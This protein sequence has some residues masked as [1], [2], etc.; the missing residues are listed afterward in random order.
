MECC[1]AP[2]EP[3]SLERESRERLH[4]L[5]GG[6]ADPSDVASSYS[7]S[8]EPSPHVAVVILHFNG[9]QDT[10]DCLQ[11]LER[12]THR[13]FDV[14]VVDNSGTYHE[15]SLLKQRFGDWLHLIRNPTNCGVPE[16]WNTGIRYALE[17]LNPA[18]ILLLNNDAIAAP[19]L[20]SELVRIA[21]E[22]GAAACGAKVLCHDNPNKLQF[23]GGRLYLSLGR[24][25]L[26]GQ[27][28]IDLGQYDEV[29][30]VDW[31]SGCCFLIRR[32]ALGSVGLFDAQYFSYF[33]DADWCQRARRKGLQLLYVP[34]AVV[35]HK[36]TSRR[37]SSR[38][39]YFMVRNH[40]L[41]VRKHASRLQMVTALCYLIF[42][43]IPMWSYSLF[44]RQPI[45]T[46]KAVGRALVWHLR[47]IG[48][49]RQ[50]CIQDAK[51]TIAEDSVDATQHERSESF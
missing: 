47:D 40:L 23:V 12:V 37:I 5:T 36:H 21:E 7:A 18:Y 13:Q 24:T 50:L 30:E 31:L 44:S 26:V 20:L 25:A 38:K 41:F 22:S 15:G 3:T 19:G 27:G 2:L 8:R 29:R 39:L 17:E 45:V 42:Y 43:A 32:E 14:I 11:S 6:P 4:R 35:W 1:R 10:M 28:E 9:M 33:E 46:T 49:S 51:P 34:T 16:G 48:K